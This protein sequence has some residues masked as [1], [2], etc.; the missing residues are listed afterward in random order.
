MKIDKS[1]FSLLLMVVDD[2][3]YEGTF[4]IKYNDKT[5]N[6]DIT[7]DDTASISEEDRELSI[8]E[9]SLITQIN[10][11]IEKTL[12]KKGFK[13]QQWILTYSY[14][15]LSTIDVE[16]VF[17]DTVNY[18]KFNLIEDQMICKKALSVSRSIAKRL[19]KELR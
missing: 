16:Y 9:K 7:I 11:L 2:K 12:G 4:N 15:S 5:F 18:I 8:R 13:F 6:K 19:L 10:K 17:D 14:H 3:R 1:N